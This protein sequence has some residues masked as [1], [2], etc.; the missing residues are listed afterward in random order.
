MGEKFGKDFKFDSKFKIRIHFNLRN[1]RLEKLCKVFNKS[2]GRVELT[3]SLT[4][5]F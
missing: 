4:A 2:L 3:C 1:L 5:D